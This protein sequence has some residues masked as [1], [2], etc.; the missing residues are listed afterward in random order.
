MEGRP[1][2][3]CGVEEKEL[4]REL[5]RCQEGLQGGGKQPFYLGTDV[6][7]L[8]GK[9][10][11]AVGQVIKV[12]AKAVAAGGQR[13]QQL[14][15]SHSLRHRHLLVLLLPCTSATPPVSVLNFLG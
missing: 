8:S 1:L 13:H 7:L 3:S 10:L 9:L 14:G 4:G 15:S 11:S 12:A 5:G 6:K 2:L